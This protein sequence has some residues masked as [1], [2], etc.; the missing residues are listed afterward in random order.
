M[1]LYT[2]THDNFHKETEHVLHQWKLYTTNF[3][4][5]YK[6]DPRY[7]NKNKGES[8]REILQNKFPFYELHTKLVSE[9]KL[10]FAKR[11]TTHERTANDKKTAFQIL[12]TVVNHIAHF[13]FQL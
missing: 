5:F 2:T 7:Y 6:R 8:I 1:E 13:F 9:L 12:L 4:W 10:Y 3:P 11:W